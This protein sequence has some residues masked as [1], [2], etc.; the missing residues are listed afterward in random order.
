LKHLDEARTTAAEAI[1]K[2]FDSPALR[3]SLYE[4]A[5]LRSD[6]SGMAE[7]VSWAN[8]K[9]G[10][11]SVMLCQ[12]ASTAAYAGKLGAARD[13]S[14]Q[15]SNAAQ[16]AGDKEMTADCEAAAAL[17]EALYGNAPE[18][19]QLVADDLPRLTGRDSQF[20]AALALALAG[21]ST[22]AKSRSDDLDKRFPYDTVVGFNYLPT[23][24]AQLAL[25]VPNN[26][27][28]AVEA[29][30]VAT[31]YELGVPGSNTLRT[32][33]YPVYVRGEA[34]LAS[35]QGAA[36]AVEFQKILDWPG[37][38]VN[39]PIGPLAHLG[40]ARAYAMAGDA[41]KSRAAYNDFFS[42][43]KDADPN[44]PVLLQAKSEYAK[45]PQ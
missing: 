13:F 12:E 4:L 38:I 45:L 36:A 7:Q 25:N 40:L 37:L 32:N 2:G 15:A 30:A 18:A 20:A 29:L 9:P 27:A 14:K 26:G 17:R 34:L 6:A 42:I 39:E 44:I 43:W 24:R 31:P 19:K 23:L 11:E 21:D 10:S 16:R 3:I 33:M 28:K 5:F 41:A 22:R 1:S 8:G 35:H